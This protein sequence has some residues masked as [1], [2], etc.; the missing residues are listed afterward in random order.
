MSKKNLQQASRGPFLTILPHDRSDCPLEVMQRVF[1]HEEAMDCVVSFED[2]L[3]RAKDWP[4][5]TTHRFAQAKQQHMEPVKV[6]M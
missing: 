6:A 1:A 3:A 4:M 2:L 5:R